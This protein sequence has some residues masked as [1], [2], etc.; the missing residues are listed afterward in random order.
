MSVH[1][2][3]AGRGE[4]D[5]TAL[6]GEACAAWDDGCGDQ[7]AYAGCSDSWRS[8]SI[9]LVLLTLRLTSYSANKSY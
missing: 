3:G 2:S 5:G 6:N 8:F 4:P 1:I 9:A 7:L